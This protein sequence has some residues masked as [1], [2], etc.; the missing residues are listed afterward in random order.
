MPDSDNAPGKMT[1]EQIRVLAAAAG[2]DLDDARATALVSQA[3][4]HFALLRQIAP[5][6]R[7]IEPAGELRLDTWTSSRDV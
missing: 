6:P 1:P 2:V 4:P 5:P 3:E 7:E